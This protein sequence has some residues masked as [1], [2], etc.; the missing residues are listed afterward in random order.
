M[1]ARSLAL[2]ALSVASAPPVF[3]A[4]PAGPRCVVLA[5]L[6]VSGWLG[7]LRAVSGGQAEAIAAAADRARTLAAL[8]GELGCDAAA[9]ATALDCLTGRALEGA[10]EADLHASAPVCMRE[11][12][13]PLR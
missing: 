9:L 3:A 5:P 8:H 1:K 13:L 10:S 2:I 12:G 7:F 6:A 4:D 11:A